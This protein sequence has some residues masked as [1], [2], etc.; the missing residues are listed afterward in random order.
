[1]PVAVDVFTLDEAVAFLGERTGL[2]H[3]AGARELAGELGCLPLGLAQAAAVIARER[4]EY[5]TYLGRLRSVPLEEYLGRVE[6]DL[7]PYRTAEAIVLSLRAAENA[8]PSGGCAVLIGLMAML[9]DAGVSR[10]LLHAA[11]PSVLGDG[12]GDAALMDGLAGQLVDASLASFSLDGL[13]LSAHRL[14]MRATREQLATHGALIATAALAVA[15]LTGLLDGTKPDWTD[16][17]WIRELAGQV[18]ALHEHVG[19]YLGTPAQGVAWDL[20][21]LRRHAISLLAG[22]GDDSTLQ[23]IAAHEKLAS[24]C[25]QVLGPDHLDTLASRDNLATAYRRAG[26][27]KKAIPMHEQA[28]ADRERVLGPDHPDTLA[29][30]DNLA[31]AYRVVGQSKKAIPMHEQALADRERVLGPDH[32]D[33][34]TS[35][36][37]L[38]AAYMRAGQFQEA[39]PMYEQALVD[40]ERVLG[41]DHFSTLGSRDNL[42][43]AYRSAG[44]LKKAI[45]MHEQ[46]LADYERVLGR[47]H[48]DT[49]ASRD[50]LGAAYSGSGQLHMAIPMQEQA[51]ADYERVLGPD[52]PDTLI[53]R[54]NLAA[55]YRAAG[56]KSKAMLMY[57]RA[58]ADSERVLGPDH[59]DTFLYGISLAGAYMRAGRLRRG[60]SLFKQSFIRARQI[61]DVFDS[62]S[63]VGFLRGR[64]QITTPW[65]SIGTFRKRDRPNGQSD[66]AD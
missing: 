13:V 14:V 56:L 42:A 22:L 4:L 26:Q 9:S 50:N 40:R 53:S 54:H 65:T 18:L 44:Q 5:G 10:R 66:S 2:R 6:G 37:N 41:H 34:L 63:A 46:V 61:P 45:P 35:R 32:P 64:A 30:R 3:G 33:T 48:V 52:H 25:E 12:N 38:A 51:L 39:I 17:N 49:L 60:I 15:V 58:F 31:T 36:D 19:H 20:L 43:T 24:D 57:E 62:D 21:Q 27:S 8:D 1:V 23:I 16:R 29:S 55:A 28:L 47:D 59:P 7:Y 11:A